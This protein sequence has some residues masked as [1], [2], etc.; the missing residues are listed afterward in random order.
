MTKDITFEDVTI[1]KNSG[2][3]LH[4]RIMGH[5][6][7]TRAKRLVFISPLAGSGA[8]LQIITFRNFI[9]R[10]CKIMSFEYSG[11]NKSSGTFNLEKS[12]E[13][14]SVALQWAS[15]YT[16][17]E[18]IPLH[19]MSTCYGTI[20]LLSTFK[21]GENKCGVKTISA[22]S[23][24]F[25]MDR[26]LKYDEF[27]P[28]YSKYDSRQVRTANEFLDLIAKDKINFNS[29]S[30]RDAIEL[31]LKMVFPTLRVGKNYFEELNYAR[32]DIK[33]TLLQTRLL[34][35]LS[36]LNVPKEL[37][38]HFFFGLRD[39][40]LGLVNPIERDKYFQCVKKIMPSAEIYTADIDHFGRGPD[41]DKVIDKL[42][43]IFEEND[44]K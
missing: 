16:R 30:F 21:D 12:L 36:K 33:E 7:S 31:Y 35:P 18:N 13:D 34:N 40:V 43:D 11:H 38:S 8:S 19:T 22:V 27:L 4:G 9:K 42:C 44:R 23:G 6:D 41:H 3:Y 2:E 25:Q 5:R 1:Q 15:N 28:I 29:G 24:L 32:T 39:N 17:N 10:D 37:S 20:S 14:T 26:I